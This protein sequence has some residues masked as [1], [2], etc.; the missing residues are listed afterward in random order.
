MGYPFEPQECWVPKPNDGG[1]SDARHS[2]W[3]CV[4]RTLEP[5]SGVQA[6]RT[7]DW[8]SDYSACN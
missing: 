8:I 2:A 1:V 5:I 3:S 7:G 4:Y 6:Y